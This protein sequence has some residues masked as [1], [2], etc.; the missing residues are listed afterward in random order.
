MGAATGLRLQRARRRHLRLGRRGE[1]VAARLV[2]EIGME[3]LA[4][5]YATAHGEID[6][7][8]RHA[9]V[10]CFVEVKTRRREI[11]YA[12]ALAV[13]FHKKRRIVRTARDYIRDIHAP[14]VPRRFDVVELVLH[15]MRVHTARYWPAAFTEQEVSTRKG[16]W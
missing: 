1:R 5:N 13:G 3:I 15:D 6:I 9:D 11:L 12:P 14:N 10:L 7:V 2:R 8:A 16:A 4:R